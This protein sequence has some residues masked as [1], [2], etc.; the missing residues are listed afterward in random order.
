MHTGPLFIALP[1]R[2]QIPLHLRHL[3]RIIQV[4]LVVEA[5]F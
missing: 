1:E 2:A 5:G 4:R 3:L